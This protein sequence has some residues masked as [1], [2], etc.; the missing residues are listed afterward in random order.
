MVFELEHTD[1]FE[2]ERT[3]WVITRLSTAE[4]PSA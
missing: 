2:T 4:N 3:L 1:Y